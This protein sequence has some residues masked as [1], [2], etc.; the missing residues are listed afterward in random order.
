M[1]GAM[2]D[3]GAMPTFSKH[4]R[5]SNLAGTASVEADALVD[6]GATFCHIPAE[7]AERLGLTPSGTRQ[8]LLANG[9]VN[10]YALA[11]AQV[12]LVD[13]G[14]RIATSVIIGS[15]GTP[16]LL[17]ALALDAFGLGVDTIGSR[18]IPKVG[19]LLHETQW[20]TI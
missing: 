5:F 15:R 18:L 2:K 10:E 6:T 13:L 4:V 20:P 12:E 16:V 9:Q 14:E 8:L 1:R 11:S 19:Y 17:G 7:L 3:K